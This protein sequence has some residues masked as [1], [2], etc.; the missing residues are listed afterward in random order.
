MDENQYF[1]NYS[2]RHIHFY[3][4]RIPD[5]LEKAVKSKNSRD[6]SV[7][8]LGCGDGSLLFSLQKRGLFSN[9]EKIVGVDL[10]PERVKNLRGNVKGAIGIV[11][12]ACNVKKLE[13]EVFDVVISSQLI[14]HLPNDIDLLQEIWR[15]VK[16]NGVVYISSV[17]K[18]WYGFYIYRNKGRFRLDPT[19]VREYSSKEDFLH[20]LERNGLKISE[21]RIKMVKY[22]LPDLIIRVFI[23]IGLIKPSDARGMY[24]ENK[25]MTLIRKLI[26]PI[27][28]YHTIEVVC[29]K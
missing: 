9:A 13:N 7:V 22:P 16:G 19:H 20:L 23:K 4:L 17:I 5:L 24:I 15:L 25:W 10:S 21:Y 2:E 29:K 28:G 8:D 18:K 11:S 1:K 27:F 26:I 14:E 3:D 12:D 6:F